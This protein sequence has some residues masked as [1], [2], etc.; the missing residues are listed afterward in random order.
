MKEMII[1]MTHNMNTGRYIRIIF[2]ML[3]LFMG[4]ASE[5]WAQGTTS[6]CGT[7]GCGFSIATTNIKITGTGSVVVKSD[8]GIV[9]NSDGG[10]T[11]KIIVTPGNDF[12]IKKENIKVQKLVDPSVVSSRRRTPEIVDYLT[13]NDGPNTVNSNVAG[14]FTFTVP[15]GY[16]SAYIEATFLPTS[17]GE[18]VRITSSS[19]I[20]D[21]D[22][23]MS[24]H[25][26]LVDDTPASWLEKLYTKSQTIAF[27]G[28][29]EG[30]AKDDGTFPQITGLSHPLFVTTDGATIRNVMLTGVSITTS[31]YTGI[32]VGALVGE[33][34]GNTRIYNCG[35]IP[36]K[37]SDIEKSYDEKE[38]KVV[39][40]GFNGNEISG[41]SSSNVGS[42]VGKLTSA[43]GKSPRVINCFSYATIGAGNIV[44]GIVGNIGYAQNQSITQ[45]TV[46]SRGMVMNCMFYGE[47]SGGTSKSP[48]YGGETGAMI[49]NDATDGVNPY[50]YFRKN[51][52]FDNSFTG[53]NDYK[54]SW[55]AEEKNLT[56]FEYYRSILNSNRRLCTWWVSGTNE[57]APTD[58]LVEDVGIAKWVLDP[59]IAPYPILKKWGKYPS[60]INRDN[61]KVWNPGVTRNGTPGNYT[62]SFNPGWVNRDNAAPYEGKKL[63]VLK[64]TINPGDHKA[65]HVSTK[66]N[67][68]FI[69][70]DIDTLNHDYGYYKIQLPYY[71]DVFGNPS[72]PASQWDRRYGGNYKEYVV[73]GWEITVSGGTH[74][75][76]NYNYADRYCTAKDNGR[77]FAQGGYYYV[78]E[79]VSS[80]TIKAHWG[81]A[82]YLANRGNRIDRVNVTN[83]GYKGGNGFVP[84]GTISG[85]ISGLVYNETTQKYTFQ[86]APVFN[87]W[88]DAIK[89]VDESGET[90][91]NSDVYNNAIVLI[92]NHQVNNG[93]SKATNDRSTGWNLDSKWHP[94]TMMS[95]DFDLDNE[96][97]FCFQL[98][99]RESTDR[100][101]IQPVRFDFLPI[102][103]LGL[104]VRHNNWAYAI[105]IF[106]P[107]GHFEVTETAFLRT[108][109]FE[110]D[111]NESGKRIS[112][113][114]PMILNGGEYEMFTVRRHSSDRTS[115]FLLGG[116]VWIHRFAPGAHPTPSPGVRIYLC[117]VSVVGG[118]I[119]E[120]YLSGLYLP[121][122]ST[123]TDQ[124]APYCFTNGGHF[125]IMA[126]AGYEKVN[127]DV[128]FEI[129]HSVIGEF[130]GGG[131]NATNPVGGKID[132][133]INHSRV[134]FYCGGPK[135]GSMEYDDNG[136][137]KYKTVETDA[138]GTTFG[139]YFGGGNGGNSYYRQL[140]KDGDQP[141]P[142]NNIIS[143][144]N[145]DYNFNNFT[146]L[147]TT[148]DDGSEKGQANG[149]KIDNKG[150][151]AE[152]DFEVFNHS[153]GVSNYITQR[154][155]IK[156]IQFGETKTGTVTNTLNDCTIN[157]NFYGGGNLGSVQGDVISTLTNVS[158]KGSVYGGGY[159]ASIPKFRVHDKTDVG[160]STN[161]WPS[162]DNSGTLNEGR[163]GFNPIV[164]EWTNDLNGMTEDNRKKTPT[165]SKEVNGE[166]KYYCYTWNPLTNLG[167]VTR[168]VKLEI[169]G[170]SFIEG[171]TFDKNGNII[172]EKSGGVFGGGDSSSVLGDT[173][174]I[175]NMTSLKDGKSYNIY[176]VF[177]G[178]NSAP[179]GGNTKVTLKGNTIVEASVFGG[180]NEGE[181]SG[182]TEVNIED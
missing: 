8:D 20:V 73:T 27:S 68:D 23:M 50:N 114:S 66:R 22:D 98:Q 146:P 100:P 59:S 129:D 107:E 17:E 147:S 172:S 169:K 151:H 61:K 74:S 25:Y 19:S 175:L 149:V 65:N 115:Y 131:I 116:N 110:Y 113:K 78:P 180:G 109:Q 101:S 71:N 81:K 99:Y 163:V 67:V 136:V 45:S 119:K 31:S 5:S 138:T 16:A 118:D 104:A 105:G 26:V 29:L 93:G 167:V 12:F 36:A 33:A 182:D 56:R 84:A 181:V 62:Y 117:P 144:W 148:Y 53:V 43:E 165:Y 150:Y 77:I 123:P 174:V 158:V 38:Y 124:G 75:F 141:I 112:G 39:I 52:S 18:T 164:Y 142:S 70:T 161:P 89:A 96:P 40:V 125:G 134:D 30:E 3:A 60:V 140:K 37:Q 90:S 162:I 4:A 69:I 83:G 10:H 64:V 48:V 63:G 122:L 46:G 1:E 139:V 111:G 13:F 153:N 127:G 42:L 54:R 160:N 152:Y 24:K 94:F 159:S 166:T 103:E 82:V 120:L 34:T 7:D 177:G 11:V 91:A 58:A 21:G 132:V 72:A 47:I 87:D 32:N 28:T 157:T 51:A 128:T 55:P 137:T 130:Y 173:K 179:V 108:T 86:N 145:G 9:H 102:V 155:F 15:K 170:N 49:K 126:G 2:V 168:D 95:A 143:S 106:V 79:G 133:T 156:W 97:D 76:E 41:G 85:T 57:I 80:I 6:S 178:G 88:Q 176:N 154:G 171:Y 35:I 92:G 121:S 44:A 135:V 14:V